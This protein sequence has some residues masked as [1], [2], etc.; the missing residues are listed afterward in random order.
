MELGDRCSMSE[1]PGLVELVSI[2]P[3]VVRV[4][5]SELVYP[6]EGLAQKV[7]RCILIDLDS[8][9]PRPPLPWAPPR[10]GLHPF[11]SKPRL[12]SEAFTVLGS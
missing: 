4:I 5:E 3:D 2:Q 11:A 7:G 12:H 10:A 1:Q 8:F 6:L 9:N